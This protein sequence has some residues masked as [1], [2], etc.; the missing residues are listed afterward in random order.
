MYSYNPW[1]SPQIKIGLE[2]R[3]WVQNALMFFSDRSIVRSKDQRIK[4]TT[5]AGG[6]GQR[7][8][9]PPKA[10]AKGAISRRRRQPKE[11]S[12][13][14]RGSKGIIT[15]RYYWRKGTFSPEC[16]CQK[17]NRT[18]WMTVNRIIRLV[19]MFIAQSK[20]VYANKQ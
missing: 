8:N 10:A 14:K 18:L 5:A 4:G 9:R 11:Q 6:G 20:S 12:V 13:A 17:I 7:N 3:L 19:T 16:R 15:R 2:R 1:R